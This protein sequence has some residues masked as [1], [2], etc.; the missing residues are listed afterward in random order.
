MEQNAM[1]KHALK[2]NNLHC[3]KIQDYSHDSQ[4]SQRVSTELKKSVYMKSRIKV[5]ALVVFTV[6]ICVCTVHIY[7]VCAFIND[8]LCIQVAV[9]VKIQSYHCDFSQVIVPHAPITI[10]QNLNHVSL[11]SLLT[12]NLHLLTIHD[13][14]TKQR[15]ASLL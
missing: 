5:L 15:Q 11:S 12:C 14:D 2:I 6:C 9:P 1:C 8:Q 7:S 13:S 3:M 10:L 4:C